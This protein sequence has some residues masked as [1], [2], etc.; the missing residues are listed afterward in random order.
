MARLTSIRSGIY[1]NNKKKKKKRLPC[2]VWK[3]IMR[4]FF[5][6]ASSSFCLPMFAPYSGNSYCSSPLLFGI[7]ACFVRNVHVYMQKCAPLHH[8]FR[9]P[10]SVVAY[11]QFRR[12]C[13]IERR[14]SHQQPGTKRQ[15][16]HAP[17][18]A[19]LAIVRDPQGVPNLLANFLK[20]LS[21][22]VVWRDSFA[23]FDTINTA[24]ARELLVLCFI[25]KC[26]TRLE[27]MCT[28]FFKR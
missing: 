7:F 8:H 27:E 4:S 13:V 14:Q 23:A 24:A 19:K 25:N 10:S 17:R 5:S 11:I 21:K 2:A 18:G 6:S 22:V 20:F 9:P 26:D 28:F 3:T 15:T 16:Q 12:G 1:F